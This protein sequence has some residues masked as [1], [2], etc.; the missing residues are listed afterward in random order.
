M[1]AA[2]MV[3]RC[4]RLRAGLAASGVGVSLSLNV[5][6][7]SLHIVPMPAPHITATLANKAIVCAGAVEELVL[8]VRL[9]S[10]QNETLWRPRGDAFDAS[11]G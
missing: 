7:L 10:L 6:L 5:G 8:R 3:C 1:S 2:V 11:G 4:A 9:V